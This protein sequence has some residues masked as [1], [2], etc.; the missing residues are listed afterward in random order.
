MH[1]SPVMT[2]PRWWHSLQTRLLVP[3]AATAVL[4]AL[5]TA[6]LSMY[7][8]GLWANREVAERVDYI[9]KNLEE[10]TFPLT[11]NVIKS[12]KDFT[13]ADVAVFD[14]QEL[15]EST[16]VGIELVDLPEDVFA[17]QQDGLVVAEVRYLTYPVQRNLTSGQRAE[18]VLLLFEESR[19]SAN[20]R[21]AAVFPLITG[22]VTLVLMSL[23]VVVL[24]RGVTARLG[25]VSNQ[26]AKIADGSLSTRVDDESLDEVGRVARSIDAMA[27]QLESLWSQVNRQQSEKLLYQ[28]ASGMAH[29]LRNTL[30]GAKMAIELHKQQFE[31]ESE[32]VDVSLGQLEVAEDYLRRLL[33]VGQGQQG[34]DEPASVT[35]C[36]E[37]V[38]LAC[39]SIA[40]H[41]NIELAFMPTT[42]EDNEF[43]KDGRSFTEAISNLVINAIEEATEVRVLVNKRLDGAE[44]V[45]VEVLDNGPGIRAEVKERLFDPFVSSKPEGM[46]L[47]L[48][49]VKQAAEQLGGR[50]EW[51]REDGWTKFRLSCPLAAVES[52]PNANEAS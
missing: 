23:T 37:T 27:T 52:R 35:S 51:V 7:F 1:T 29:Q 14:E 20:A 38:R 6:M 16:L 28:V 5:L 47:G 12:L 32:E 46:G 44:T 45:D 49:V 24:W 50:I 17:E 9:R 31:G 36:V 25:R 15:V 40:K 34:V 22:L 4:A 3:L 2:D 33:L 26:V 39:Q 10:S 13:G 43:V 42:L 18:N 21:R 11:G 48:P 8:G 19:L 41:R 30:T